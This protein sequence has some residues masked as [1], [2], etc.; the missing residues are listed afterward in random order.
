MK[1]NYL[2]TAENSTQTFSKCNKCKQTFFAGKSN[3]VESN[4]S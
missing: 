1:S 2:C 3:T 4:T